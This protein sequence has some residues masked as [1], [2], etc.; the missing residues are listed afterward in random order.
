MPDTDEPAS[1][2]EQH[3]L[4]ELFTRLGRELFTQRRLDDVLL[5]I[6]RRAVEVVPN[7]EHAAVSRT[8]KDGGFETVASTSDLPPRVD[9]IQYRLKGGPCVDAALDD[10][11]YRLDEL[12]IDRRWPEFGRRAAEQENIHSMLSVRLFLEDDDLIAGLN[13]YSSKS[14][15]FGSPDQTNATLLATHGALAVEAAR[16][17]DKVGNLERALATSR[18]IGMAMGILMATHKVTEEQA[19]GLLRIASQSTH[20]KVADLAAGVVESG[21]LELPPLPQ[22]TRS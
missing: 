1:F 20:R 8:K 4:A 21:T 9:A 3:E 11:V 5:V 14:H 12:S 10:A 15:A 7:A 6:T 13:L 19:F 16:H 22:K 17:R 18:Q 2:G